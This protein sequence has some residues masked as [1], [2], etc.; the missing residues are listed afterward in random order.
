[1]VTSIAI[2]AGIIG[3]ALVGGFFWGWSLSAV[4]GLATV[5]DRTYVST[6]QSVNRAILNPLFLVVFVGSVLVLAGATVAAFWSGDT[7]RGWWMAAATGTY[8]VGVFGITVVGNVPLNDRLRDVDLDGATDAA[9]S[10]ARRAYEG[11]WNRLHYVRSALG[12]LAIAFA[13][14]AALTSED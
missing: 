1:M 2:G 4:P 8:A 3:T 13:C 14:V 10:E 9:V 6:M 12:V 5:T 11:P 7:R